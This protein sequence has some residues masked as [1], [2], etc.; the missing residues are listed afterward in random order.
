VRADLN[1]HHQH[2][3]HNRIAAAKDLTKL[4]ASVD[5][6][7][8]VIVG[9]RVPFAPEGAIPK[10]TASQQRLEIKASQTD[11]VS[12]L[13]ATGSNLAQLK[14]F[15]FIPFIALHASQ[16]DLNHLAASPEVISI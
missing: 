16:A 11:L 9:L 6:L 7:V 2:R 4:Q 15:E 5:S 1:A 10:D 3:C 13:C 14:T 12:Q 8:P